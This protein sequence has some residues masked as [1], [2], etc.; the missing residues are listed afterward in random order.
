MNKLVLS[1]KTINY[2]LLL[3]LLVLFVASPLLLFFIR[4]Y[5]FHNAFLWQGVDNISN[6][7]SWIRYSFLALTAL[8]VM[9]LYFLFGKVRND[10]KELTNRVKTSLIV[11]FGISLLMSLFVII[12][13]NEFG[14]YIKATI[15]FDYALK[16]IIILWAIANIFAVLFAIVLIAIITLGD[17]KLVLKFALV[18][19]VLKLLCDLFIVSSLKCSF[20][21][22]AIGVK[23]SNIIVDILVFGFGLFLLATNEV[24]IFNK[25]ALDFKWVKSYAILGSFS[26]LEKLLF[27]FALWTFNSN[28]FNGV[29]EDIIFAYSYSAVFTTTWGILPFM[30]ISKLIMQETSTDDKAVKNNTLAYF[31]LTLIVLV[32]GFILAVSSFFYCKKELVDI[33]LTDGEIFKAAMIL[34]LLFSTE[35]IV[36]LFAS[37]FYGLEKT[38]YIL[39]ASIIPSC[40]YFITYFVV[41][42]DG[43]GFGY[44]KVEAFL[45]LGTLFK[46]L[47]LVGLYVHYLKKTHTNILE[48]EEKKSLEEETEA[49]EAE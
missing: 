13:P 28:C 17:W 19:F 41:K 44:E 43:N 18:E 10:K 4:Q 1:F 34:Y 26:A 3:A 30:A 31:A 21:L 7:S 36:E 32:I 48:V 45:I 2:K 20:D 16:K 39:L 8:L 35:I 15:M 49:F 33:Q 47:G 27:I 46:L 38:H 6:Q 42:K 11:A 37:V 29:F 22:E 25:E 24:N 12:F 23:I 5:G 14:K 9:P 40:F